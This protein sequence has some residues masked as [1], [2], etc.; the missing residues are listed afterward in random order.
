M[1]VVENQDKKKRHRG[2]HRGNYEIAYDILQFVASK[3]NCNTTEV[4]SAASL[5][6]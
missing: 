5:T 1:E 6:Y 4:T 3:Y 2:L